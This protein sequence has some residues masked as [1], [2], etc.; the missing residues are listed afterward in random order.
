MGYF[1]CNQLRN[2][3]IK[4][5][6][7]GLL[8]ILTMATFICLYHQKA[9]KE[10]DVFYAMPISFMVI[11]YVAVM[12]SSGQVIEKTPGGQVA[13]YY[14]FGKKRLGYKTLGLVTDV[15]LHQ[16]AARYYWL[17]VRTDNGETLMLERHPTLRTA[18][19]R[20]DELRMCLR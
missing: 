3:R 11:G 8:T 18:N 16:D 2:A 6:C 10:M 1:Y 20:L 13:T 12:V 19:A 5:I 7:L 9:V 14:K 4:S 17:T 15:N